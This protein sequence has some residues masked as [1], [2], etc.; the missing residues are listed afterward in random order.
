VISLHYFEELTVK[1][2]ATILRMGEWR[3]LQLHTKAVLR[4]RTQLRLLMGPH[5]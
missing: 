3:V 2:V 5:E 1:E 4:L